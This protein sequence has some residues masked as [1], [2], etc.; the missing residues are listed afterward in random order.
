MN[1]CLRMAVVVGACLLL[2]TTAQAEFQTKSGWG[3][4]LFP[5][6]L[7][8]TATVKLP[9]EAVE[10]FENQQVLGDPQGQLGVTIEAPENDTE[11][12]V[13]IS[14]DAIMTPS[15]C[16]VTLPTGGE[17]YTILPK[18]KYDYAALARH[19]QPCPVTVTFEVTMDDETEEKTETLVLRSINDC[20]FTIVDGDESTDVSLIFAAYVNEQ[21]PFVDKMLREALD[22]RVVDSFTGYQSKDPAEVYRQA[23]ALWHALSKRD[24]RYSDITTSA[25]ASDCVYSQH[26]RMIDES[27][28][29]AQANCADGSVLLASL[30][31]KVGI[32][33]VL[34]MVPGHCYLAFYLDADKT[35]LAALETTL[36]GSTAAGEAT[37]IEGY[38]EVVSDEWTEQNSWKTFTSALAIGHEDITKNADNFRAET[39]PNYQLIDIAAARKVGILPIA[40]DSDEVFTARPV[41]KEFDDNEADE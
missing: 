24:V 34:V 41:V 20:P 16:T 19:R 18:I 22:T 40:F 7:I 3:D 23:Y 5:S 17:T 33:P 1:A 38:E 39:D 28:G 25:A 2:T 31:R 10:E 6:Y 11:V 8:A 32:E 37:G 36:L 15:V 29:N 14:C 13:T 9:Q 12:T 26:V 4:Q 35:Q 30:L 27:I 21:H